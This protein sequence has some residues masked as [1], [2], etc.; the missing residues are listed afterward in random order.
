VQ[1]AVEAGL[2]VSVLLEGN[3][4]YETMRVLGRNDGLPEPP[5]ADLGLFTRA[6]PGAQAAAV[7]T[8]QTFLCEELNLGLPEHRAFEPAVRGA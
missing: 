5:S 6:A 7:Q 2:G 8:L 4:R 3:I 1:S